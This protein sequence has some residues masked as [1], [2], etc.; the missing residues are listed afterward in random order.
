MSEQYDEAP[1]AGSFESA[2]E[3]AVAEDA[4]TEPAAAEEAVTPE[5]AEEPAEA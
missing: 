5:S 3:A 1:G 4:A 2:L